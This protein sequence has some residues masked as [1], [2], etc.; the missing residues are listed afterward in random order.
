MIRPEEVD[1]IESI[2][3]L[4][5][6]DVK[7][8][9]TIGGFY[10]ATSKGANGRDSVLAGGSHPALVR[11][12]LVKKFGNSFRPSLLK[13]EN[14][15]VQAQVFEKNT[16]LSEKDKNGGFSI[17]AV[18]QGLDITMSVD[19]MG[20][21]VLTQKALA[22]HDSV[23]IQDLQVSNFEKATYLFENGISQILL[24]SFA[25]TAEDLKLDKISYAQQPK[26]VKTQ[27]ILKK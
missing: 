18:V 17:A 8:I 25:A 10:A 24:K 21:N 26:V 16:F 5:G 15:Q 1:S 22:K 6:S 3:E 14:S 13:S 19:Y 27:S 20:A 4:N 23:E 2:G 12:Q 11:H 9:R 7:V